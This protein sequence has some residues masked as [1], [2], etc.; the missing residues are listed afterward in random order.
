MRFAALDDDNSELELIQKTVT[1]LGHDCHTFSNGKSLLRALQHETFDFLVLDW[2]LPDT[3][4]PEVVKWVRE[5]IQE[6]VP[7][8][9]ITNRSDERDVVHGLTAGA[10]DFMSKPVRVRE[11]M[12]RINAL[13]RRLYPKAT[14]QE[15]TWGNYHCNVATQSFWHN[16]VALNL[17][18]KEFELALFLFQNLGR[19]LSRQHIQEQVWGM[20][21]VELQTRTLDTH[22]SS[23]R[24]KLKLHPTNGYRL[25]AVYGIGYRLEADAPEVLNKE[26]S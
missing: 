5:N 24:T 18:N 22:I 25:T 17:K 3:S 16:G 14:Q 10:D 9:M 4:G 13:L 21:S 8:L 23:V 20:Q 19:L 7:I 1:A 2:E 12:A 15:F 26:D 11:L 6:A